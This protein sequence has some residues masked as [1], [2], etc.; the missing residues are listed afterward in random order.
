MI[1]AIA[2]GAI[3]QHWRPQYLDVHLGRSP[4]LISSP[5]LSA[6][7]RTIGQVLDHTLHLESLDPVWEHQR[8]QVLHSILDPPL[9]QRQPTEFLTSG[10]FSQSDEGGAAVKSFG[11]ANFLWFCCSQ[12][13]PPECFFST[14][15]AAIRQKPF[16]FF[17]PSAA[18]PNNPYCEVCTSW[19]QQPQLR[20]ARLNQILQKVDLLFSLAFPH[21]LTV[22]QQ[23][24][25]SRV[26]LSLYTCTFHQ[27]HS[28]SQTALSRHRKSFP[29]QNKDQVLIFCS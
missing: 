22:Q 17:T 10:M 19:Y 5:K 13:L 20:Q 26:V 16:W 18:I 29:Y 23:R 25:N 14:L 12:F 6:P 3:P 15:T 24:W 11:I 28:P 9:R 4:S 8:L 27:T 2:F 21:K 1:G 7:I